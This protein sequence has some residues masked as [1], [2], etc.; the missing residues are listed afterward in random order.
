MNRRE[1]WAL[2]LPGPISNLGNIIIHNVL[3][4]Y[5]T[6]IIGLD[7]KFIGWVYL[8]YNI[9]NAINDPL[10]GVLIDKMPYK[11]K[12]GKYVYLMRVTTPVMILAMIGMVLNSPSLNDWLIFAFLTLELFVF[13]TGY[14]AFS[15]GY[16]SFFYIKAPTA[17]DR[18]NVD[19]I[20]VYV[21]NVIS[22]LATLIPTVLLVGDS[23]PKLIIPALLGVVAIDAVVMFFAVSIL[24]E[25][26]EI[27]ETIPVKNE[28]INYKET[29][30][31]SWNIIK[32]RPFWTY[33]LF[34]ITARGAIGFYFTPFLYYM[35]HV[36]KA[37][38]TGATIADVLPGVI[39]LALLP[40]LT[41]IIKKVGS[42][43]AILISYIPAIAGYAGLFINCNIINVVICYIL[44]I[45]GKNLMEVACTPLNGA[46]IDD[47]E[48]RTGER[49]TG[50]VGGIFALGTIMLT[51]IQQFVFSNILSGFGY[52]GKA[53]EITE[54]AVLG[55]RIGT[56]LVPIGFFILGL[57]PLLLFPINKKREDELS[58]FNKQ[59]RSGETSGDSQETV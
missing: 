55:I 30:K 14:T 33:L 50:L 56:C 16:N 58:D 32:A 21:A 47:D 1:K 12:K 25:S 59:M 46:L 3:M 44:I 51:S 7:A 39:M 22:F 38:S 34:F 40:L 54:Q 4:K 37:G 8:I 23:N 49:K 2:A 48:M 36:A 18:V 28:K 35:D 13:D 11:P 53:A 31:A 5:Y 57:I 17:A 29:L 41:K 42:K 52:D 27:Y 24:K 9:W 26:S 10:F 45:L 19:V 20:R 6:D 43:M 15:I